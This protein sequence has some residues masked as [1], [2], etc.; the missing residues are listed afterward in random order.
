MVDEDCQFSH[1]V[2]YKEYAKGVD[3]NRFCMLLEKECWGYDGITIATD[4]ETAET[5]INCPCPIKKFF[6]VWNLE[7][8]YNTHHYR[9]LQNI[10]QSDLELI[11]RNKDHAKLLKQYWKEPSYTMDNFNISD[12]KKIIKENH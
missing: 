8:L 2:F 4:L 6:Y 1:I 10:Y 5:L 11:A 9:V 7:W 12:L 3:V